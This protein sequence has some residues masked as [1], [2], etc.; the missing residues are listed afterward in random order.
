MEIER[1]RE[2][3]SSDIKLKKSIQKDREVESVCERERGIERES[4][5]DR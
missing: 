1:E 5:R 4:R 2:G 3:G